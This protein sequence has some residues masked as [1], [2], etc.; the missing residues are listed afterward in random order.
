MREDCAGSKSRENN[1]RDRS[2]N[3]VCSMKWPYPTGTST[4]I[5]IS[6]SSA[7]FAYYGVLHVSPCPAATLAASIR[8]G[9][10]LSRQ[11]FIGS[12]STFCASSALSGVASADCVTTHRRP[13]WFNTLSITAL[14]TSCI[15]QGANRVPCHLVMTHYGAGGTIYYADHIFTTLYRM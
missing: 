5:F 7:T 9:S 15:S 4:S 11:S 3:K 10:P 14:S 13:R 1:Q 2:Q 12:S 6:I 8:A